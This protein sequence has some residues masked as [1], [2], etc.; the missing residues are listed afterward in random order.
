[1]RGDHCREVGILIARRSTGRVAVDETVLVPPVPG[2][3]SQ[4][5]AMM[6]ARAI[7]VAQ[8]VVG[9][10]AGQRGGDIAPMNHCSMQK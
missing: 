10:E 9:S 1:M 8:P 6:S 7:D 2:K 3:K 5:P 4:E